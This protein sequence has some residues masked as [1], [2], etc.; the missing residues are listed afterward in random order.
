MQELVKGNLEIP[1]QVS[2]IRDEMAEMGQA[3]QVFKENA[4]EKNAAELELSKVNESRS[5]ILE[6]VGQ[7]IYGLLGGEGNLSQPHGRKINGLFSERIE[8]KIFSLID[9]PFQGRWNPISY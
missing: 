8:R 3:L 6:S 7:G 2:G 1:V 5:L 4:I 9:S